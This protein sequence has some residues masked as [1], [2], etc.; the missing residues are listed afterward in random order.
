MLKNYLPEAS[1][2]PDL[3][4]IVGICDEDPERAETLARFVGA[5]EW[6][7]DYTELLAHS[8][9]DLVA[10]LASPEVNYSAALAGVEAGKH[11]YVERPFARTL[12]DAEHLLQKATASG[13]QVMAAPTLMLD[14]S[15]ALIRSLVRNG[16]IG[17]VAFA[18]VS[19]K[20]AG[21]FATAHYGRFLQQLSQADISLVSQT[22]EEP[23]FPWYFTT[24]SGPVFDSTIDAIT[25]IT[26]LIGPARRVTAFSGLSAGHSEALWKIGQETLIPTAQDDTTLLLLDFGD[27]RYGYINSS[28][29]GRARKSPPLEIIGS[30]GCI[31]V[32]SSRETDAS[33]QEIVVHVFHEKT[34][35]WDE[36]PLTEGLWRIPTG[37]THLGHCLREGS[38]P[39][40]SIQHARH[41]VEVMEKTCLAARTGHAQEIATTF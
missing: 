15:N 3:F 40:N 16:S 30:E 32:T 7:S 29:F 9:A 26:G 10:V 33:A 12:A 5:S 22:Q 36:F 19:A 23:V 35:K 38:P 20:Q 18:S 39:D 14:P 2:N 37:L 25:R 4:D 1:E 17:R 34:A 11:V 13:L 8:S 41:V 24:G 28:W 31:A 21:E 27:A 6:F